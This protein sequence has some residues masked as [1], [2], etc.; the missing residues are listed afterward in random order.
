MEMMKQFKY[1]SILSH[2]KE[3]KY[4]RDMHNKGWR[5]VR[6]TGFGRYHFEKCEPADVIYRLDYNTAINDSRTEYLQMFS[7]CGWEYIQTYVGYSYFCK[8]A[9]EMN[10]DENIFS[11]SESKTAM[12]GRV[13]KGRVL[14]LVGIFCACLLP[15]FIT[16]IINKNYGIVALLGA[17]LGIYIGVFITCAISY[18][19]SKK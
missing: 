11:D 17:I 9:S 14:P 19:K 1:F 15:Q 12:M 4:L 13:Y 10:S 7:D 6:V 2:E 5:F 16:N 18:Y 8:P 3:E